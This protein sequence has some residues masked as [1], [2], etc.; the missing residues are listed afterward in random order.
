[1]SQ[2]SCPD[3]TRWTIKHGPPPTDWPEH[4]AFQRTKI[5]CFGKPYKHVGWHQNDRPKFVKKPIAE[6][7]EELATVGREPT[8]DESGWFMG[9]V[10][11][12]EEPVALLPEGQTLPDHMLDSA[13][14]IRMVKETPLMTPNMFANRENPCSEIALKQS[15]D[16]LH[17][18]GPAG[19]V[20]VFNGTNFEVAKPNSPNNRATVMGHEIYS[21][22]AVEV[23]VYEDD[24][25]FELEVKI[26]QTRCLSDCEVRFGPVKTMLSDLF[27]DGHWLEV[28]FF[29]P[30]MKCGSERRCRVY[31]TDGTDRYKVY[32]IGWYE[33]QSNGN[34]FGQY[35]LGMGFTTKVNLLRTHS[36]AR[37]PKP[38]IQ[39]KIVERV[40]ERD[41]FEILAERY[42]RGKKRPYNWDT[43]VG[44]RTLRERFEDHLDNR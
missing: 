43:M 34:Q 24:A 35:D 11:K 17:R 13:Q 38:I 44:N 9:S 19:S 15:E 21:G 8:F 20:Y 22:P 26:K 23:E 32:S 3:G 40:V 16:R 29:R 33:L 10:P 42:P 4:M 2:Q 37:Y 27:D 41:P 1:M 28:T 31:L 5:D 25:A 36:S 12:K 18:T 14:F 6:L 30:D 39:E 7:E